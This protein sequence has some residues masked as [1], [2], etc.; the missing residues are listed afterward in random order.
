MVEG[1]SGNV[2]PRPQTSG[3]LSAEFPTNDGDVWSAVSCCDRTYI[4]THPLDDKML[5]CVLGARPTPMQR[6]ARSVLQGRHEAHGNGTAGGTV[7]GV[8]RLRFMR[9]LCICTRRRRR[10]MNSPC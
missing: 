6:V 7:E 10:G 5:D 1:I 4:G 3:G 9:E 2:K 8:G